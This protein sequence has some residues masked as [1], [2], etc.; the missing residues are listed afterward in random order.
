MYRR[1]SFLC[2]QCVSRRT[3]TQFQADIIRTF[4]G[5]P[6]YQPN[7]RCVWYA[8]VESWREYLEFREC[9]YNRN[10]TYKVP[11]CA[12]AQ[13]HIAM[14]HNGATWRS[15]HV[16]CRRGGERRGAVQRSRRGAQGYHYG[17]SR[18]SL[19]IAGFQHESQTNERTNERSL[20]RSFA[21]SP[22]LCFPRRARTHNTERK[23]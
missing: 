22:S 6:N 15:V 16:H 9:L 21:R 7:C 19:L 14:Q 10:V 12:R 2:L 20:A 4:S 1:A 18:H 5:S 23:R 11:A 3:K 17:G 8:R 13:T